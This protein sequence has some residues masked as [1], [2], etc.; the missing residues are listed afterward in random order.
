MKSTDEMFGSKEAIDMLEKLY[1][2]RKAS[3]QE[4]F[5]RGFKSSKLKELTKR[6]TKRFVYELEKSSSFV[7]YEDAEDIISGCIERCYVKYDPAKGAKFET[8]LYKAVDNALLD[9]KDKIARGAKRIDHFTDLPVYD[10]VFQ[11]RIPE[12]LAVFVDYLVK[13]TGKSQAEVMRNFM[14]ISMFWLIDYTE[15][16]YGPEKLTEMYPVVLMA[17]SEVSAKRFKKEP[18]RKISFDSKREIRER[19]KSSG[20]SLS[21]FCTASIESCLNDLQQIKKLNGL[22]AARDNALMFP[23]VRELANDILNDSP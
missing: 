5:W 8:Y 22:K 1:Q 23:L 9:Y 13:F 14:F 11:V 16:T 7:N 3:R 20:V 12:K 4:E 17:F 6:H 2:Q 18:T 21:D 19:I 10:D 15:E